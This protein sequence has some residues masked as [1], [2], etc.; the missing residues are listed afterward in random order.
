MSELLLSGKAPH[1]IVH[2][3]ET[4]RT[5]EQHA[6][7]IKFFLGESLPPTEVLLDLVRPLTASQLREEKRVWR[8]DETIDA[9]PP[10]FK[11]GRVVIVG[12]PQEGKGTILF[13]LSELCELI[14]PNG[15]GYI[16]I[17]GHHQEVVGEVVVA[18]IQEAERRRIP[19]FF[20]SF[21]YLA[22]GSRKAGRTISVEKQSERSELILPAITRTT[23]PVAVTMHT[24]DWAE[25]FLNPQLRNLL[26]N[27]VNDFPL[28]EIPPLIK[29]RS[30]I[31]RFL[32]DHGVDVRLA[33]YLA[34]LPHLPEAYDVLLARYNYNQVSEILLNLQRYPVLKEIVRGS[35]E[36]FAQILTDN[37][38]IIESQESIRL[39]PEG[40][41]E[42]SELTIDAEEKRK[43]LVHIRRHGHKE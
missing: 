40:L 17:D 19:I 8:S 39:T 16:F 1:F 25:E 5:R 30:S 21:D 24:D 41:F 42:L 9:A 23:V 7:G 28:Y 29:S 36:K 34:N 27:C 2:A 31:V 12:G 22:L 6:D 11:Q 37:N 35:R 15:V 3:A 14:P 18:A 20:D 32:Y 38:I 26:I 33:R 43:N 4:R 10:F 13:G